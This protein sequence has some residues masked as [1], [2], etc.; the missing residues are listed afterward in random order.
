MDRERTG[1]V[2]RFAA[3]GA[4]GF[5]VELAVLYLLR[6]KLGMD[7]LLAAAAAFIVSVVVNY[8]MCALWVFREAKEQDGKSKAAFFLTSAAGLAINEGMMLLFRALWGE[9]AVLFTVFSFTV[10]MYLLNKVL[11]TFVV[12]VWNYFT[13]RYILTGKMRSAS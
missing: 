4:A 6:E 5:A 2:L 7:T 13:K 8:L 9:D 11:S 12:M 10:K 3:A 1:E